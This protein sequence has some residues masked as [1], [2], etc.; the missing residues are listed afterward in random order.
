MMLSV[1]YM[2][3]LH[4]YIQTSIARYAVEMVH[5]SLS[6]TIVLSLTE[7]HVNFLKRIGVDW[8]Y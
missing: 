4:F 5:A 2:I 8:L 3:W 6:C 7:T 1:P